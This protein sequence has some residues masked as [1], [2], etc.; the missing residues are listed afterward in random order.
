MF[1]S[2]S[3]IPRSTK[4]VVRPTT[5]T[6]AVLGGSAWNVPTTTTATST[7]R[8]SSSVQTLPPNLTFDYRSSFAPKQQPILVAPPAEGEE[9]EVVNGE[10]EDEL[11][12]LVISDDSSLAQVVPLP[13][14]LHANI[15]HSAT[16]S[17]SGTIWLDATVFGVDPIRVDLIKQNVDYIRNKIRGMRKAHSKTIAFVSGS[18]KKVRQQKGTGSARAGHSRPAHWRGG[19]KAHGP[20]NTT[21]YGNVKMNSKAKRWAMA[22]ALSQKLKEGNLV[23]VDD[24]LLESHKTGPWSSLLA[25]SFGIGREG[26]SALIIDH[27]LEEEADAQ[28]ASYHGV[29]INLW[30]ASSNIR[31]LKVMNVRFLNVYDILKK[32]KLVISLKAL[33]E[34]EARWKL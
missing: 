31:P 13:E 3:L 16:G 5:S 29:P 11:E 12:E 21:N 18:G 19:A 24:F 7:V 20:K 32:E 14:R 27:Y 28:H 15:H 34:I 4:W 30:V 26:S 9:A 2:L 23:V 33:E 22:S 17:V 10:E 1:R 8:C 25:N 6:T